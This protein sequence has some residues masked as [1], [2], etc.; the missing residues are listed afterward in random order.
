MQ[1]LDEKVRKCLCCLHILCLVLS[2]LQTIRA[3]VAGPIQQ[4]GTMISTLKCG[5]LD[6]QHV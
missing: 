1:V 5:L 2:I 3:D 4:I 6:T